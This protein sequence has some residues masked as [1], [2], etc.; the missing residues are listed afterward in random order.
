MNTEFLSYANFDSVKFHKLAYFIFAKFQADAYFYSAEFKSKAD[1]RYTFFSNGR[2]TKAHFAETADFKFAEFGRD[3]NFIETTFVKEA[4]FNHSKLFIANFTD[5]KFFGDASFEFAEFLNFAI[6]RG[7]NKNPVFAENA[8]LNLQNAIIEKPERISFHTVRLEPNWF[9]D[10]NVR[11]FVFTI[12]RWNYSNGE[13]IDVT[14]EIQK[15]S[16]QR[17]IENPYKHLTLTCWQLADNQ[18]E[19]KNFPTASDF[20]KFAQESYRQE[21]NN[22]FK[23]W[24]LQWWYWLSSNYGESPLKAATFLVVVI[25]G[26]AI[27]YYFAD[28][29]VSNV[30][31]KLSFYQAFLQS[32][33]TATLQNLEII[34]PYS[35]T[36]YLLIISERI[37]APLQAALLA[38]AI[39]RKFMR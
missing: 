33:A 29:Q 17:L 1:F 27:A 9:V 39:R 16:K 4:K 11:Q 26:Y 23:I 12:C 8:V 3:A 14:K 20:R 22:K 34:K 32:V 21:E 38:L 35:N 6:F 2:F 19:S 7:N 18:E 15:L 37:F 13:R 30:Q 25:L 24:Y 31:T 28:F 36:S 5:A 10:I